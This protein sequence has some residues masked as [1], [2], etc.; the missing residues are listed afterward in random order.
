MNVLVMISE[1]T[2]DDLQRVS[3]L[4][5]LYITEMKS[6]ESFVAV[7]LVGCITSGFATQVYRRLVFRLA[8]CM[9]FDKGIP[10]NLARFLTDLS[11]G[12]AAPARVSV[13]VRVIES[14]LLVTVWS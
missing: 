5:I 12:T 10:Q 13:S 8:Q 7:Q 11:S 6:I 1:T 2:L 14:P 4:S 9:A 3:I